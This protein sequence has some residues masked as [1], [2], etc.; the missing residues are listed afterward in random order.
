MAFI[1]NTLP[2]IIHTIF[3]NVLKL[4]FLLLT[5]RGIV[6]HIITYESRLFES[7]SLG[8]LFYLFL[9]MSIFVALS[10]ILIGVI[11][12]M[13]LQNIYPFCIM[14]DILFIFRY[15]FL[16][17]LKS[18]IHKFTL[19]MFFKI[20]F[21]IWF[22]GYIL[23]NYVSLP[24]EHKISIAILILCMSIEYFYS[25]KR[26]F[27]FIFK[28][29]KEN[30]IIFILNIILNLFI[31]QGFV[32]YVIYMCEFDTFFIAYIL[33]YLNISLLY[34]AVISFDIDISEYN[35]FLFKRYIFLSEWNI[36]NKVIFTYLDA[37]RNNNIPYVPQDRYLEWD[38][39]KRDNSYKFIMPDD[40]IKLLINPNFSRTTS[41]E[42]KYW[43]TY[44]DGSIR[45]LP[46]IYGSFHNGPI[47]VFRY[48]FGLAQPE[49]V[50][51][52]PSPVP[53]TKELYIVNAAI[54]KKTNVFY[55]PLDP[56]NPLHRGTYLYLKDI[57][58]DYHRIP[59]KI[60]KGYNNIDKD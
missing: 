20:F 26:I 12:F 44:A 51:L 9:I 22:M 38:H 1:K 37:P 7:S 30:K 3:C 36:N 5:L 45:D 34:T 17:V 32:I 48:K 52:D 54:T 60:E 43:H 19:L 53:N 40:S 13:S 23:A 49:I 46:Y 10:S 16:S 50:K 31:T 55:T 11:S 8:F 6:N 41:A 33:P 18:K 24:S 35:N 25:I 57:N 42:F 27:I 28:K 56:D 14:Y 2:G 58:G 21:Y 47:E 39:F 59:F 29:F 4:V 15:S